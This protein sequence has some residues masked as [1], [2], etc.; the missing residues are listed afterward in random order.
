MVSSLLRKGN[1]HGSVLFTVNLCLRGKFTACQKSSDHHKWQ[2]I[3]TFKPKQTRSISW[4]VALFYVPSSTPTPILLS[5]P[6]TL[7]SVLFHCN[8]CQMP[9]AKKIPT[10]LMQ[11]QTSGGEEED[12]GKQNPRW[13]TKI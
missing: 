4:W 13:L 1:L 2:R 12:D 5:F 10:L 11:F 8:D 7:D 3:Y 6:W 9:T